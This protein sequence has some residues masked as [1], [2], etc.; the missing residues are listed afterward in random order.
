MRSTV[1]FISLEDAADLVENSKSSNRQLFVT[2]LQRTAEKP[3][4]AIDNTSGTA[5]V[6][7]FATREE[8]E[9]W[10]GLI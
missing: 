3:W 2:K 6:E 4:L 5:I 9:Q 1:K 7:R 8:A 10:S